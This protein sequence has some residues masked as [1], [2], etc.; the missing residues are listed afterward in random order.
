MVKLPIPTLHGLRTERLTFRRLSK[1][2][3]DWWM[4]YINDAI[5]IRFMPFT[6]GSR[7]DCEAMIKRSLDRYDQ[8]GSGLHALVTTDGTLVGQCGLLTQEVDGVA[9]LEVGYHLHPAHWGNGYASEA[10]IACKA[11]A[12]AEGLVPSVI[13]LID[14][15]NALS[16]AVARR[17][18]MTR[19]PRTLHR[20]VP[21]DV[22]R[23]WPVAG[24]G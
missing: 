13:S 11:F 20:G 15:G 24:R 7:A 14:P 4:G 3:A 8:D 2:D 21:A 5:A 23:A 6:Q 18:G 22:W 12:F 9:E 16:Q 17:N 19:G 10:A 1:A